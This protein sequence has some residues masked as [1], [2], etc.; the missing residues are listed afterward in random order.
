M[1]DTMASH[2][3][4]Y[5]RIFLDM[6]PWSL[7][8]RISGQY[9]AEGAETLVRFLTATGR[10]GI[11]VMVCL[12]H[13]RDI[14]PSSSNAPRAVN[15]WFQRPMHHRDHG[16]PYNGMEA[17]LNSEAGVAQFNRKLAFLRKR[18]GDRPEVFAWEL[19]NEMDCVEGDWLA[20]TKRTLPEVHQ[21]GRASCRERV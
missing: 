13:F 10:R 3:I 6:P 1:L 15:P 21:I 17:Y 19:W 14:Q 4:N 11:R 16:G 18:C 20:W 12:E 2:G 9:D 7:E 5:C 8:P